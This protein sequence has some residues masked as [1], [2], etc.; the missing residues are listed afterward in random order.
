MSNASEFVI[1]TDI[2]TKEAVLRLYTGSEEIVVI[3]DDVEAIG[4]KAFENVKHFLREVIVPESVK[5]IRRCAFSDCKKLEKVTIL[6]AGLQSLGHQC[7]S[8]CETLKELRLPDSVTYI[9]PAENEDE[10]KQVFSGC[11]ALLR[12]VGKAT[13]AGDIL[14]HYDVTKKDDFLEIPQGVRFILGDFLGTETRRWDDR[15]SRIRKVAIPEGVVC[16]GNYAFRD[17]P[18]LKEVTLPKSVLFVGTGAFSFDSELESVDLGGAKELGEDVFSCCS[19]LSQVIMA[20]GL[21]KIGEGTFE[22]CTALHTVDLPSSLLQI[23]RE[24]R[25]SDGA[26]RDSGVEEIVIPEGVSEIVSNTFMKCRNLRRVVL[27]SSLERIGE[28]AFCGCSS[29][30][31]IRIPDG[32]TSI[33]ENA[34]CHCPDLNRPVLP[35]QLNADEAYWNTIGFGDENGCVVKDGVLSKYV[36]PSSRIVISEGVTQI[37]EDVLVNQDGE[38][39]E[40]VRLPSS[41]KILEKQNSLSSY[42]TVNLPDGYLRSRDKI[43]AQ[44]T[45]DL[46]EGAWKGKADHT[47]FAAIYLFQSGK[48]LQKY[49]EKKLKKNPQKTADS[50]VFLIEENAKPAHVVKVAEFVL[51]YVW[52]ISAETI[53]KIYDLA[54]RKRAKKAQDML[55]PYVQTPTIK[56]N[57]S[58]EGEDYTQRKEDEVITG[59]M[60]AVLDDIVAQGK[61]KEKVMEGLKELYG[62]SQKELPSIK[63]KE[64]NV[65]DPLVIAWLLQAHEKM[66][67]G[68]VLIGYEKAGVRPE[69]IPIIK[70]L[71]RDSWQQ[72]ILNMANMFLSSASKRKKMFL[73]YP[74]CRYADEETIKCLLNSVEKWER[75][76]RDKDAPPIYAFRTGILYSETEGAVLFSSEHGDLARYAGLRRIDADA[77]KEKFGLAHGAPKNAFSDIYLLKVDG[78]PPL[79]NPQFNEAPEMLMRID[80]LEYEEELDLVETDNLNQQ[81]YELK[82]IRFRG[83][84]PEIKKLWEAVDKSG[85]IKYNCFLLDELTAEL[86]AVANPF[87]FEEEIVKLISR[88]PALKV[89]GVVEDFEDHEVVAF[90]SESGAGIITEASS[91]GGFDSKDD[92]G[93]GRWIDKIDMMH[94]YKGSYSDTRT[95][96]K[97]YVD[98]KYPYKEKW[99]DLKYVREID[100]VFYTRSGI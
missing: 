25:C 76:F 39:Y 50:F 32:V 54:V 82:Q 57:A 65:V 23:G 14:V 20:E 41:L 94:P 6:G 100:G 60:K 91:C 18:K 10:T 22:N 29:L 62:I 92:G 21:E 16:I 98:Y 35:A 7:F 43:P 31:D 27:P 88:F 58:E 61:T 99:E 70:Q 56:K 63:D 74:I 28:K 77:I 68:Y 42:V 17:L 30:T 64:G 69:I 4:G 52:E 55:E 19:S 38:Y 84:L 33:G 95:G 87:F 83:Y 26:F 75:T 53:Q 46:L 85:E 1:E 97:E 15:C 24:D 93:R 11:T 48:T 72:A 86:V 8:G 51:E 80:K 9:P 81:R 44:Y 90:F 5:E 13:L 49:S 37:P 71:D 36:G 34:F 96:E 2:W 66:G 47:D 45:V 73:A 40:S 78:K 67:Y 12:T 3:P 89:A 79:S 59:P